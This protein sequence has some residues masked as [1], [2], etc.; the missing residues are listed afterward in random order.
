MQHLQWLDKKSVSDSTSNGENRR[1]RLHR[2]AMMGIDVVIN[3]VGECDT[4]M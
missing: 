1:A 4:T 2:V 3:R